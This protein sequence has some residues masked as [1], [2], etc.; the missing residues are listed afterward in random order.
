ML[1]HPLFACWAVS[2]PWVKAAMPSWV[3]IC[4][5]VDVLTEVSA[6]WKGSLLSGGGCV[7]QGNLGGLRLCL[8][9]KIE[10]LFTC[11]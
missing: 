5:Q 3:E 4:I 2:P 10:V 7:D 9:Y 8:V 6:C 1:E 11:L